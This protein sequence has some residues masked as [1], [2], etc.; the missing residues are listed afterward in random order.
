MNQPS[1]LI[2]IIIPVY[3]RPEIFVRS[4]QSA[5]D[6]DYPNVEIIVV[7]DGSVP[8][9]SIPQSLVGK[10]RLLRQE[11]KGAPAARN[12]G[13]F[14]STGE[15]VFFW[16]A[17][18]VAVRTML[19]RLKTALDT[20]SD[21]SYAYCDFRFGKKIM[22]AQPFS[23]EALKRLNYITTSALIRRADFP[24]FDERLTKFQDWDLWLT[25]LEKNK[26]GVYVPEC[27]FQVEAGGTMSAWLPR[28]AYWAPWKYLPGIYG[29]VKKYETAKQI[30]LKKHTLR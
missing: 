21:T 26:T 15:L 18:L 22:R 3:N 28:F 7:D 24:G 5:I 9:I 11:N 19:S 12:Y 27:L 25:M 30:I 8:A 1:P 4:L 23:A 10:V 6:Q 17:D 14:N 13:F 2:S 29:R 20:N 16:D